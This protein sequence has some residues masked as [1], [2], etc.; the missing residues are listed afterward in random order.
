MTKE[1]LFTDCDWTYIRFEDLSDRNAKAKCVHRDSG[2]VGE[3]NGRRY[4]LQNKK[5]AFRKMTET[6][7]F[8][9]WEKKF[10]SL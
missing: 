1:V 9:E 5:I 6:E 3:S 7:E 8:K 4:K 2:A 10:Y